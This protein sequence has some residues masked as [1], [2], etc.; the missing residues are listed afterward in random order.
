MFICT[1][2]KE[3]L[4]SNRNALS[5]IVR[6]PCVK[7]YGFAAIEHR[8]SLPHMENFADVINYRL[9]QTDLSDKRVNAQRNFPKKS[10]KNRG[11]KHKIWHPGAA[12]V[13]AKDKSGLSDYPKE[14]KVSNELDPVKYHEISIGKTFFS[15]QKTVN[16]LDYDNPPKTLKRFRKVSIYEQTQYLQLLNKCREGTILKIGLPSSFLSDLAIAVFGSCF[17][18]DL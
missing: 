7:K 16:R 9:H 4:R 18:Y 1:I 6:H 13:E 8:T 2:C 11:G 5:A 3:Q 10:S 15:F 12:L 14:D 17:Q